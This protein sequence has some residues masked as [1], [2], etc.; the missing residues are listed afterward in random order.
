[1]VR[2]DLPSALDLRPVDG[3]LLEPVNVVNAV[4][5]LVSF[6]GVGVGRFLSHGLHEGHGSLLGF[7]LGP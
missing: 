6:V 4:V 3:A 5:G 2:E 7:G 1:M